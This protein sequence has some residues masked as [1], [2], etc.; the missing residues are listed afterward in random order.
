[1]FYVLQHLNSQQTVLEEGREL[2]LGHD[3][4]F[5]L[6]PVVKHGEFVF[7]LIYAEIILDVSAALG[8]W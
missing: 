7:L 5:L 2:Y 3:H 8:D 4:A 6:A 1:M